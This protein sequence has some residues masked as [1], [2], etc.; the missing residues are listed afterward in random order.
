MNRSS[1]LVKG[2]SIGRLLSPLIF[3]EESLGNK[4][5][6]FAIDVRSSQ[7]LLRIVVQAKLKTTP[8]T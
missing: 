4:V 7:F 5:L 6:D 8:V 1:S 2:S 3:N